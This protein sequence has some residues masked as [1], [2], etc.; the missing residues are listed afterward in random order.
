M[1]ALRE[2]IAALEEERRLLA[3]NSVLIN[4]EDEAVVDAYLDLFGRLDSLIEKLN[5][6]ETAR[7]ERRRILNPHQTRHTYHWW[8]KQRGLD[9]EE[10]QLL[11]GHKNPETTVRQ[12][13]RVDFEVVAAKVAAL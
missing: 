13:G 12:Y 5:N 9:L 3:S 6:A 11:M 10:R 4:H 1:T 7:D 2:A 8:L